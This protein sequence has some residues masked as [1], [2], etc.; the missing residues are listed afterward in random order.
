MVARKGIE[1]RELETGTGETVIRKRASGDSGVMRPEPC[2]REQ[3]LADEGSS[4]S[5]TLPQPQ[6]K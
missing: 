4:L 5:Y 3:L 1:L 6:K 2:P